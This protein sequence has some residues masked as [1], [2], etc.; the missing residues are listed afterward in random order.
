MVDNTTSFFQHNLSAATELVEVLRSGRD[1]NSSV[2][3]PAIQMIIIY[4]F[5]LTLNNTHILVSLG[6]RFI[7]EKGINFYF[8]MPY[9]IIVSPSY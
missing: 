2:Q 4:Y 1:S 3:P 9:Q 8:L 7:F 5:Y 6:N